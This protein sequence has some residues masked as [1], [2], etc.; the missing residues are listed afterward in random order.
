MSLELL[1]S[2]NELGVQDNISVSSD[3]QPF[4][5]TDGNYDGIYDTL[6]YQRTHDIKCPDLLEIELNDEINMTPSQVDLFQI[7][8]NIQFVLHIGDYEVLTIPLTFLLHLKQYD[9]YDN[10]YYITIPFNMFMDDIKLVMLQYHEVNFYLTNTNHQ[11]QSCSL[12]SK[13]IYAD[14][15]ERRH[16]V[17]NS[18]NEII[19]NV[20]YTKIELPNQTNFLQ[21]TFQDALGTHKG[22]FIESDAIDSISFISLKVNGQIIQDYNGIIIKKRCVRI[23]PKLLYFPMNFLQSF[24]DRSLESYR[25]SICFSQNN[26][27][28]LELHF[29]QRT[30]NIS[31]YR[32]KS[33]RA[34][35]Q[36]GMI[37]LSRYNVENRQPLRD[38]RMIQ[39]FISDSEYLL[40][41][42]SL[43]DIEIDSIYMQ[44]STCLHNYKVNAILTWLNQQA[45]T[46]KKCPLC[47][48]I[49]TNYLRYI[50]R[51]PN[52]KK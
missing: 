17:Q 40:C 51:S 36:N 32:L 45:S 20:I 6:I 15:N 35:F 14:S 37:Y 4:T 30:S 19:Q 39:Q 38:K 9:Y 41:S 33:T 48:T 12:I 31:I 44:C 50:N 46:E 3:K 22:F 21:Y 8:E 11:F 25:G 24:S 26:H 52:V 7:C 43:S 34:T 10:K 23:S 42:I 16:I 29:A 47:R 28:Y 5:L 2:N 27:N 1:I 49:W 13:A 18:H